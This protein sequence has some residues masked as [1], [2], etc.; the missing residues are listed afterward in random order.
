MD[1]LDI[2]KPIP[3]AA[4]EA[5]KLGV[6]ISA[7]KAYRMAREGQLAV[8][9]VGTAMTTVRSIIRAL[10]PDTVPMDSSGTVVELAA[11]GRGGL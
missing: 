11:G 10:S 4:A 8:S 2:P 6:R 3:E 1:P 9:R 7:W 5:R